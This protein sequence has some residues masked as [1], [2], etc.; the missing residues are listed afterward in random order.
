[1]TMSLLYVCRFVPSP[2]PQLFKKYQMTYFCEEIIV[3]SHYRVQNMYNF[4]NLDN[5]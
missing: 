2:V 5:F 3:K 4:V 1:M